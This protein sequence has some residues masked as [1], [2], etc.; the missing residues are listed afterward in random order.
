[1]DKGLLKMMATEVLME[2]RAETNIRNRDLVESFLQTALTAGL[3]TRLLDDHEKT[4]KV[5]NQREEIRNLSKACMRKSDYI[6]RLRTLLAA[7]AKPVSKRKIAKKA[8]KPQKSARNG[9]EKLVAA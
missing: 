5:Y 2:L 3:Q 6:K 9:S 4:L 7:S 8:P 1:M